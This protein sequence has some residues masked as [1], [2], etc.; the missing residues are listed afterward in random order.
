MNLDTPPIDFFFEWDVHRPDMKK[1][2]A[3]WNKSWESDLGQY[4]SGLKSG[5]CPP[6]KASPFL[7][8]LMQL[9]AKDMEFPFL[10]ETRVLCRLQNDIRQ[11]AL[12][13]LAADDLEE[14]WYSLDSK[15][16]D[17]VILEAL[18]KAVGDS[19]DMEFHR[20]WCPEMTIANLGKDNGRVFIDLLQIV[21]N[22]DPDVTNAQ[23][24]HFPN[25]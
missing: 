5:F 24:V 13:K 9:S 4:Y 11:F 21:I 8:K 1:A 2:P 18:C 25:Q 20:V 10:A 7:Q 16:R 22:E 12:P 15:R 19:T 14:G 3:E 6:P 23:V 17:E